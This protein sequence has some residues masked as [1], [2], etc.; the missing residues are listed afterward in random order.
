LQKIVEQPRV[1]LEIVKYALEPNLTKLSGPENYASWAR[2][3]RLI[4]SSHD[5]EHLLVSN[6]SDAKE[7]MT[8]LDKKINDR[9][10]VWMLESMEPVILEQ[11]ETMST[12]TEVWAALENQFSRKSNK[13]Q[14]T[15]I[16]HEL[17]NLKQCSMS[18][19][20]YANNVRR[21]YR[22]LHY[23]H[24]LIRSTRKILLFIILGSSHL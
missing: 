14:V 21:L 9:I 7:G 2:Y 1:T 16:M 23:Y 10:L 3:V 19:T 15:R 4:L 17:T 5:Y 6:E 8:T 24:H 20:E 22:D 11:V 12:I 13:M 18:V